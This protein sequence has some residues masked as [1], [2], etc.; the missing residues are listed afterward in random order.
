M[1]PEDLN[2]IKIDCANQCQ[3]PA[4]EV[5]EVIYR[6]NPTMTMGQFKKHLTDIKRKDVKNKLDDLK[7]M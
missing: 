5:I 1:A 2:S 6:S 3:N 7:G 4:E